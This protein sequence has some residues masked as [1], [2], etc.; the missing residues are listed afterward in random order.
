MRIILLVIF[1]F[2]ISGCSNRAVYNNLQKYKLDQCVK[3][4]DFKNQFCFYNDQETF[5]EYSRNRDDYLKK[6]AY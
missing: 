1:C 6:Q 5:D 3:D 4:N 2:F